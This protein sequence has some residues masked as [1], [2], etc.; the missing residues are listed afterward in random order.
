MNICQDYISLPQ[1]NPDF[2][3]LPPSAF[4]VIS[5]GDSQNNNKQNIYKTQRTFS[6][7]YNVGFGAQNLQN[8]YET[9]S[10]QNTFAPVV[11]AQGLLII[12]VIFLIIILGS[13]S[14]E[15]SYDN[16]GRPYAS[17]DYLINNSLAPTRNGI[18]LS[19]N[20]IMLMGSSPLETLTEVVT[21]ESENGINGIG[22]GSGSGDALICSTTQQRPLSRISTHV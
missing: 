13:Y 1:T 8:I 20:G 11:D 14:D 6:N 15:I 22:D 10:T 4:G 17:R 12:K 7:D 3:Y 16:I 19:S 2:D 21:P 5:Y 9:Y 18:G